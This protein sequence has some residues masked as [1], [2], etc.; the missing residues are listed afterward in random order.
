[1][2][3]VSSAYACKADVRSI[4]KFGRFRQAW[5][6]TVGFW[7]V[8]APVLFDSIW[9]GKVLRIALRLVRS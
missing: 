9:P 4:N 3:G 1:M 6:T 8:V 7:S 5:V 2:F